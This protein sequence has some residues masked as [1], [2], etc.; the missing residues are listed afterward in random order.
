MAAPGLELVTT[1]LPASIARTQ[2][3]RI[4]E[5]ASGNRERFLVTK[6]GDIKAIILGIE[7]FL[8]VVGTMPPELAAIEVE[9]K[10]H[11]TDTLTLEKLA[12][13][14]LAGR[15]AKRRQQKT[16]WRRLSMTPI[17]SALRL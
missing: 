16:W 10:Q 2:F 12:A 9:A 13:E 7:D 1:R 8:Q 15:R 5:R 6:K 14:I 11:G 4:L 17:S 3:G